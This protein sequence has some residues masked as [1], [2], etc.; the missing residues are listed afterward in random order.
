MRLRVFLI[1]VMM[2]VIVQP[3]A[4]QTTWKTAHISITKVAAWSEFL[5]ALNQPHMDLTIQNDGTEPV[6]TFDFVCRLHALDRAPPLFE[7]SSSTTLDEVIRP[8]RTQIVKLVP[9]MFSELGQTIQRRAS[10]TV[11]SCYVSRVLTAAGQSIPFEPGQLPVEGPPFGVGYTPIP[12]AMAPLLK[13]PAGSGMW[14]MKVQSGSAAEAAGLKV[15]DALLSIDG[16]PLKVA[17]DLPNALKAARADGR[18]AHL[19]VVR[20]G[21]PLELLG[22][23]PDPAVLG[24]SAANQA[25]P[26]SAAKAGTP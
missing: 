2:A 24:T 15:G 7:G 5:D 10:N 13:V 22:P 26:F 16:K 25:T 17:A 8:G 3:A 12:D 18:R 19:A 4:A 23:P 11:W 20:A 1:A 6:G 14:V 9:N 21:E